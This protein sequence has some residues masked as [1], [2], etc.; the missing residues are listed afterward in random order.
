[1]ENRPAFW[2][3][4]SGLVKRAAI[5]PKGRQRI[6]WGVSPYGYTQIVVDKESTI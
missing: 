3:A 4:P 6:A 5:A 2:I 1:M